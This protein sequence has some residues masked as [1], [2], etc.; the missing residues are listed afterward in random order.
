[1]KSWRTTLSG[2]VTSAAS[3]VIALST[4]GIAMPRWLVVTAGFVAA[5]GFAAMGIAS[6]DAGGPFYGYRDRRIDY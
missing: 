2:G 3:L 4:A 6:K 1:M 5:G